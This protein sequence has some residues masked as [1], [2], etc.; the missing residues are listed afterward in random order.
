MASRVLFFAP[1]GN[2]IVHTQLDCVIAASLMNRGVKVKLLGCDGIFESCLASGTPPT[3]ESCANCQKTACEWFERFKL[4]TTWLSQW[5]TEQ[6]KQDAA[7]WAR[8]VD[9]RLEEP[10]LFDDLPLAQ[11]VKL[12]VFSALRSSRIPPPGAESSLR[13]QQILQHGALICRAVQKVLNDFQPE[14]VV[15]YSGSNGYYRVFVELARL[16]QLRVLVHERGARDGCFAVTPERPTYEMFGKAHYGWEEWKQRPLTQEHLEAIVTS[17][18]DRVKGKNTNFQVI[19]RFTSDPKRIK[20]RLRLT[21]CN[22]PIVL[23]ACSGDW[24]FG[25]ISAFGSIHVQWKLQLEWLAQT[26]AICRRRD[27]QLIIRQH[28]LGAGK[29][30]Y[31][32]ANEW[33]AELLSEQQWIDDSVRVIMPGENTSTYDL[34]EIADVIVAQAS[35][36]PAEALVRGVPAV[37]CSD[38]PHQFMGI[39][40]IRNAADYEAELERAILKSP[41]VS[42]EDLRL[43]YRYLYFRGYVV[44]NWAFRSVGIKNVYEPDFRLASPS[45]LISGADPLMDRVC[46]YIMEGVP[47]YPLPDEATISDEEET[48]FL[49]K[50]REQ[51]LQ[52]RLQV[53]EG[54]ESTPKA[55]VAVCCLAELADK[56]SPARWRSRHKELRFYSC[57]GSQDSSIR[58]SFDL[59]LQQ[60]NG[61]A[62]DYVVVQSAESRLD[63]CVLARAIDELNT[64]GNED[65]EGVLFGCYILNEKGQLGPEWNTPT[66]P[67]KTENAP[68]A[69]VDTLHQPLVAVCMVVWRKLALQ[70]W[71]QFGMHELHNAPDSCSKKLWAALQDKTRF[72][73][74]DEPVIYLNQAPSKAKLLEELA[75]L[76]PD[77]DE[78]LKRLYQSYAQRYTETIELRHL[79]GEKRLAQKQYD[80]AYDLA[81]NIFTEGQ[82][83]GDTWRLLSRAM[84]EALSRKF[85]QY[86]ATTKPAKQRVRFL[87]LH[88]FYSAYLAKHYSAKPHLMDLTHAEQIQALLAD[89]FGASHMWAAE[90]AKLGSL[91]KLI[92][93]NDVVSQFQ[94]ARE[95]LK[96]L[97]LQK[98]SAWLQEIALAQV[99]HYQPEIL[100]LGDPVLFDMSFVQRLKKRPQL[101]IGWRAAPTPDTVNWKE[102]DLLLSHLSSGIQ[103]AKDRGVREAHEF[104]PGFCKWIA[105]AVANESKKYDL[106]FC[107]QWSPDHERR[108]KLIAKLAK[109]SLSTDKPFSFGLFLECADPEQL[110]P[111]VRRLNRGSRWGMEMYQT[112]RQGRVVLNA[113]IDM[114]RGSAGNMRFFEV[115]GVGSCLLT[116]HHRNVGRYFT[117]DTEIVTFK[118]SDECLSKLHELLAQPQRC[119]SVAT[120]GQRRC[121]AAHE[122]QQRML[123]LETLLKKKTGSLWYK[124]K[125]HF[126]K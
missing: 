24:E 3:K 120:A 27:W 110:P 65:K 7:A 68:P 26:A 46:N 32:R 92:I 1:F 18:D 78:Q 73:N 71:L 8:E 44:G 53:R 37:C 96:E 111:A 15:C 102:M 79:L 101:V 106:V 38:N 80:Q 34:F 67:I 61:V 82:A 16:R 75:K 49:T 45:E 47:L 109:A 98:K 9:L 118:N 59:L 89:G 35:R 115:T 54:K 105:D 91:T 69:D 63:E 6:D 58:Q 126:L 52:L 39:P 108:N 99:N 122:A 60:L 113:E 33:L 51:L 56:T 119:E 74:V 4:D 5:L 17:F 90:L 41:C 83:N 70:K 117:P 48:A 104:Y 29:P 125:S 95:N 11:W 31:P 30:S 66:F 13:V 50:R 76:S 116:E 112:L 97:K 21:D 88:S 85:S 28:P 25:M 2:W 107:G 43:A 42:V 64:V 55:R 81:R 100:H 103:F 40:V 19:H 57:V 121:L 10:P 93:A 77:E 94:W 20:E 84:P 22:R 114:A 124:I 86:T 72:V 36:T 14:A 62:E 87:Q 23:A 123:A 12:A